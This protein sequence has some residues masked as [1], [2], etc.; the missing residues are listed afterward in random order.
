[1]WIFDYIE[2]EINAH[3]YREPVQICLKEKHFYI[4]HGDGV[5]PGDKSYKIIKKIF[6]NKLCQWLFERVHP[7]LGISIAQYWSKKVGIVN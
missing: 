1:M 5:G 7:N 4:G 6:Q 3:I 2:T